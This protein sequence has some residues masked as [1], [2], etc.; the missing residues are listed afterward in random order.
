[1]AIDPIINKK[2]VVAPN[3]IVSAKTIS[4]SEKFVCQLSIT[5]ISD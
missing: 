3:N 5:I 2:I 1:M 4:N